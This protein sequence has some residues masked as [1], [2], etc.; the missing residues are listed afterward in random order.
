[1]GLGS[2]LMKS[3]TCRKETLESWPDLAQ[4][5]KLHRELGQKHIGAWASE[6]WKWTRGLGRSC[7]L[8]RIFLEE[9]LYAQEK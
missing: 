4:N 5:K 3:H 1:M 6:L 2:A 9:A 8:S 7:P